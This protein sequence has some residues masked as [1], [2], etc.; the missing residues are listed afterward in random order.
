MWIARDGPWICILWAGRNL[1]SD[2]RGPD[3]AQCPMKGNHQFSCCS[4]ADLESPDW[5]RACHVRAQDEW[6]RAKSARSGTKSAGRSSSL[7]CSTSLWRSS[8]CPAA[9]P[10]AGWSVSAPSS[11]RQNTG[12]HLP[13]LTGRYAADDYVQSVLVRQLEGLAAYSNRFKVEADLDVKIAS[14]IRSASSAGS[15][16]CHGSR[17]DGLPVERTGAARVGIPVG[18]RRAGGD[19]PA[20]SW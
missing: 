15:A 7:T 17:S 5:S 14:G 20:M 1:W 19:P 10:S 2:R 16:P 6:Q 9:Y 11:E 13:G 3:S 12:E 4:V 18:E 8:C